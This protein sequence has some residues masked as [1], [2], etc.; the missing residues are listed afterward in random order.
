MDFYDTLKDPNM[1]AIF[2]IVAELIIPT[3]YWEDLRISMTNDERKLIFKHCHNILNALDLP[4][5][6]QPEYLHPQYAVDDY[7]TS[8]NNYPFEV[9]R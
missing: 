1:K 3:H 2:P 9:A 4:N 7:Y 6:K 8:P 5:G